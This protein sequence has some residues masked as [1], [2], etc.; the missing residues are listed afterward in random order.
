M[1]I[2]SIEAT[3][4]TIDEAK[5]NALAQLGLSEDEVSMEVLD[6]GKAALFGL[7][8]GSPATGEADLDSGQW[9]PMRLCRNRVCFL[10]RD[11]I[12][13][14]Y[15]LADPVD[16]D[17]KFYSGVDYMGNAMHIAAIGTYGV[18]PVFKLK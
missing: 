7:F 2:K 11:G 18:R 16:G 8:G 3:G 17:G 9:Q 14:C 15:W 4:K 10:G 12:S 6:R 5:R 1:A 13:M